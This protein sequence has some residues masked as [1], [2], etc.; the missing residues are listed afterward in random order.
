M[1]VDGAKRKCQATAV[2]LS[3]RKEGQ[4]SEKDKGMSFKAIDLHDIRATATLHRFGTR[5]D[6]RGRKGLERE[7][8]FR[9]A[10][11]VDGMRLKEVVVL[12]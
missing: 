12:V 5:G 4:A 3:Q 10:D 7:G 8:K 2:A 11:G 9:K 6:G 1:D